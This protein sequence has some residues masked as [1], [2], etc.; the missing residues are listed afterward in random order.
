MRLPFFAKTMYIQLRIEVVFLT[1][2][3][4]YFLLGLF[5]SLFFVVGCKDGFDSSN[6]KQS[7]LPTEN[8]TEKPPVQEEP[9]VFRDSIEEAVVES[10]SSSEIVEESSSSVVDKK[11]KARSAAVKKSSS[12]SKKSSTSAKKKAISSSSVQPLSS[13]ELLSSSASPKP[14]ENVPNGYMCDLR[15]AKLYRIKRIGSQVWFAENLNYA[16]EDSWCYGNRSENCNAFGR[17]YS[18]TAAM[19][20]DK[21]FQ[22]TSAS[23]TV[24][25]THQGICP[26]GWHVPS[27]AE[28]ERL[29]AYVEEKNA[30]YTDGENAGASLKSVTGWKSCDMNEEECVENSDRYGFNAKPSGWRDSDGSFSDIQN[31]FAFWVTDETSAKRASYWDLYYATDKFWGSY[32][33]TKNAAYSVRC[34]QN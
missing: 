17:L 20:L 22:S 9:L 26:E 23:G 27:M 15:E 28:V 13:S 14:C 11:I 16:A 31:E 5:G 3:G 33:N 34:L 29:V 10:S 32:S 18:W 24:S 12:S 25:R 7:S 30:V 6:Q 8:H 19:A 4:K 21:S 1:C 2:L